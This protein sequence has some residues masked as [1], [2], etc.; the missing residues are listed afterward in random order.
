MSERGEK[1]QIDQEADIGY[2][3]QG[4]ETEDGDKIKMDTL[5]SVRNLDRQHQESHEEIEEGK[6]NLVVRI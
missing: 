1:D 3:N 4:F 2:R 5:N 6:V